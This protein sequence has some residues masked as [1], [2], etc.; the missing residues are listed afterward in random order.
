MWNEYV[1]RELV[2]DRFRTL[3][4]S[5]SPYPRHV[6]PRRSRRSLRLAIRRQN[7]RRTSLVTRHG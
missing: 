1:A 4:E 7:P 2:A 3:Q 6:V 5:Y